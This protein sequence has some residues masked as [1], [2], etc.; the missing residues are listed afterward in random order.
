[1]R[2]SGWYESARGESFFAYEGQSLKYIAKFMLAEF[3]DDCVGVDIE[4]H[5]DEGNDVSAKLADAVWFESK[6]KEK[7]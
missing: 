2:V 6:R 5:D 3:H 7:S 1:M 4:A